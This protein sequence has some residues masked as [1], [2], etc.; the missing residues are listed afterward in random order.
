MASDKCCVCNPDEDTEPWMRFCD[1]HTPPKEV[2]VPHV[3]GEDSEPLHDWVREQRE[4]ARRARGD[5]EVG[6]GG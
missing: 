3:S 6:D 5:G 4:L 2:V 1:E